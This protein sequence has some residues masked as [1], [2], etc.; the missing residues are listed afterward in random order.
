MRPVMDDQEM[1]FLYHKWLVGT[2]SI[3]VYE[4]LSVFF[5]S[6]ACIEDL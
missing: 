5:G 6:S 3:I 2:G 4:K 1:L